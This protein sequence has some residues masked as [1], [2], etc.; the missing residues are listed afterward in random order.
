MAPT[1]AQRAEIK[2]LEGKY[3]GLRFK[4]GLRGTIITTGLSDPEASDA[5]TAAE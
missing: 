3:D 1:E 4:V 5:E 2:R